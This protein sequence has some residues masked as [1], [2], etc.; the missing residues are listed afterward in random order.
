[1]NSSTFAVGLVDKILSIFL[2]A[3]L[4][5]SVGAAGSLY[6]TQIQ[7][8]QAQ[9]ISSGSTLFPTLK[10]ANAVPNENKNCEMDEMDE[11][12]L[13]VI[14]NGTELQKTHPIFNRTADD[15]MLQVKKMGPNNEEGMVK[16]Y[17]PFGKMIQETHTKNPNRAN[18]DVNC[19]KLLNV[20][21]LDNG[22][23]TTFTIETFTS[24][25]ITPNDG[26]NNPHNEQEGWADIMVKNTFI[27]NATDLGRNLTDFTS[28]DV[29]LDSLST[30]GSFDIGEKIYSHPND[31]TVSV[32]IGDN[33]T[34]N[35]G[36][37]DNSTVVSNDVDI[38]DMPL[39]NFNSTVRYYDK[40]GDG[41]FSANETVYH[42]MDDSK[43]VT[44]NDVRL[45]NARFVDDR[46]DEPFVDGK[47]ANFPNDQIGIDNFEGFIVDCVEGDSMGLYNETSDTCDYT[48]KFGDHIK[49][50]LMAKGHEVKFKNKGP[51]QK[52]PVIAFLDDV[53]FLDS[54]T[55]NGK[56]DI[57]ETIYLHDGPID[58]VQTNDVRLA[59][60]PIFL[61]GSTVKG[62]DDDRGDGPLIAFVD[63][64]GK[65]PKFHDKNDNGVFDV[66]ETVYTDTKNP[67]KVD[68]GEIRLVNARSVGDSEE[69]PDGSEVYKRGVFEDMTGMGNG[70]GG[71]GEDI[72]IGMEER[73]FNIT[74]VLTLE[75]PMIM[76]DTNSS[77]AI[78]D[79]TLSALASSLSL[80][81]IVA[82]D[83]A[84][85]QPTVEKTILFG[86]TIAPF[87]KFRFGIDIESCFWIL[88]C[89]T[90]FKLIIAITPFVITGFR[91]P[92]KVRTSGFPD[93]EFAS[94]SF[95]ITTEFETFDA[96]YSDFK[97][98]CEDP[99]NSLQAQGSYFGPNTPF[100]C[101]DFA[102]YDIM[103]IPS[104]INAI[105]NELEDRLLA[106]ADNPNPQT[107][108]SAL[109]AFLAV[110]QILFDPLPPL[111]VQQ[112][113]DRLEASD[114]TTSSN[115]QQIGDLIQGQ[116]V[117]LKVGVIIEVEMVILNIELVDIETRVEIDVL[118]LLQ[119]FLLFNEIVKSSSP[120]IYNAEYAKGGIPGPKA[121][122]R[123]IW[124]LISDYE[125]MQEKGIVFTSFKAPF[126]FD[127]NGQIE[128]FPFLGGSSVPLLSGP[129]PYN[130]LYLRGNCIDAWSEGQILKIPAPYG[131]LPLCSGL[132]YPGV[133]QAIFG[134]QSNIGSLEI[135]ATI[136]GEGDAKPFDDNG[137]FGCDNPNFRTEFK[138]D[139]DNPRWEQISYCA[140][141]DDPDTNGTKSSLVTRTVKVDNYDSSTDIATIKIDDF[142]YKLQ[143]IIIGDLLVHFENP[144]KS[145][146]PEDM[147][148]LKI[149]MFTKSFNIIDI[150]QH[151]RVAGLEGADVKVFNYAVEISDLDGDNPINRPNGTKP[152]KAENFTLP[153]LTSYEERSFANVTYTNIGNSLD[154]IQNL[155]ISFPELDQLNPNSNDNQ[156]W[157]SDPNQTE[158]ATMNVPPFNGTESPTGSGT[159]FYPL[160]I[161]IKPARH[162]TTTPS[163]ADNGDLQ[164]GL[165]E[166]TVFASSTNATKHNM[167]DQDPLLNFRINATN[168]IQVNV[169]QYGD[170]QLN[171][172]ENATE[173]KPSKLTEY[174]AKIANFGND[175]D[176]INFTQTFEDSNKDDCDVF[177]KGPDNPN[178]P[179]R[180]NYTALQFNWTTSQVL[181]DYYWNETLPCDDVTINMEE[182]PEQTPNYNRG[183]FGLNVTDS[184]NQTFTIQVPRDW[185]G[186]DDTLYQ[187]KGL[188]VSMEDKRDGRDTKFLNHTVIAT[189]ESS[190]RYIA[191]EIDTM[192]EKVTNATVPE[193]IDKGSKTALT[194]ILDRAIETAQERALKNVC[195]DNF[196]GTNGGLMTAQHQLE[197]LVRAINGMS[198]SNIRVE[199]A[200]ELLSNADAT[201]N[202][203]DDAVANGEE[204]IVPCLDDFSKTTGNSKKNDLDRIR[205]ATEETTTEDSA[206]V[207]SPSDVDLEDISKSGSSS[208]GDTTEPQIVSGFFSSTGLAETLTPDSDKTTPTIFETGKEI[209]FEFEFYENSGTGIEHFELVTKIPEHKTIYDSELWIEYNKGQKPIIHNPEGFWSSASISVK[210]DGL[211]PKVMVSMVFDKPMDT[212]DVILRVWDTKRN[213]IDI[214]FE[215]VIK[216][217]ESPKS[218]IILKPEFE[219]EPE[220]ILEIDPEPIFS[221]ERFDEWAGYSESNLTDEE[222]LK[223]LEI[224]GNN[225][226]SWIKQN[227]AKWVKQGLIS[228]DELVIALENLENRGII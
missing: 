228:Q 22:T 2:I 58:Q 131:P 171:F 29:F 23:H 89:V 145:F 15:G 56:F 170:P 35:H 40:N 27:S 212:S 200:E 114:L 207:P 26:S 99:R 121:D 180:A 112:I 44:E 9:T 83:P 130:I 223:H 168:I 199:F 134:V 20:E 184:R 124:N 188:V 84:I 175:F 141:L 122:Y 106:A 39:V 193:M 102:S 17:S 6:S 197:G 68:A 189:K 74:E 71:K 127:E 18:I 186:I 198:P 60:S 218:E 118:G 47:K 154:T 221:W 98:I 63:L 54:R 160:D 78:F 75:V 161:A 48:K 31:M 69:F 205:I 142:K 214:E 190:V 206:T 182:P 50:G 19:H 41:L 136:S 91:L 101:T 82:E 76:N 73:Q 178:C 86:D 213:S 81:D 163:F 51:D 146:L 181:C 108:R 138:N 90:W 226:P 94:E 225:I 70:N 151:P 8:N 64:M 25:K 144:A 45:A 208:S 85:P 196:R 95:D 143:W 109:D 211:N 14:F 176:V 46:T 204:S 203:I 192:K 133:A 53:V 107:L 120:L 162:W 16:V 165:Y 21:R 97:D 104:V 5:G 156:R 72:E 13:D 148:R 187:L 119:G 166:V 195:D 110:G 216:V 100:D 194:Q 52:L 30:I 147:H 49:K 164:A 57:G 66:G 137:V 11:A 153:G 169:T 24:L 183:E 125:G 113:V 105:S 92:G 202:D 117:V 36:A 88:G 59:N 222:F 4:V 43:N 157:M 191:L 79:K 10:V 217:I 209:D 158:I 61:N 38:G 34:A 167:P 177:D 215:N 77:A 155:T 152:I 116:E 220:S 1:M 32:E 87:V 172:T 139:T 80:D 62:I 185:A 12:E 103:S 173:T 210:G 179:F 135:D 129:T 42:D 33:R 150:P 65:P 132:W 201:I 111:S 219:I 123:A 28:A 227:N 93:R 174:N 37:L 224:D 128:G 115:S 149:N 3:I 96:S 126:G 159:D 140:Y 55:E 67:N 7:S